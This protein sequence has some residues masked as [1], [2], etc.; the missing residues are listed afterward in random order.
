M[1]ITDLCLY[2]FHPFPIGFS[3]DVGA[4]DRPP[5]PPCRCAS[6]PPPR[7]NRSPSPR[8]ADPPPAGASRPCNRPRQHLNGAPKR[9]ARARDGISYANQLALAR[10]ASRVDGI[11]R[12]KLT[13]KD[14]GWLTALATSFLHFNY[15]PM[16]PMRSCLGR[17][18]YTS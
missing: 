18:V 14:H 6:V 16:K 4:H 8:A 2:G 5:A 13:E 10:Q 11:P 12:L 15:G 9:P 3:L 1:H 7:C 17:Q